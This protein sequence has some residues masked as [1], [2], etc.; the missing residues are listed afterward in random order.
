MCRGG[1]CRWVGS[2]FHL[3]VPADL[4][5]GSCHLEPDGKGGPTSPVVLGR[6]PDFRSFFK[7]SQ[8]LRMIPD[9]NKGIKKKKR[10]KIASQV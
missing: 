3:N 2:C 5:Q 1:Q 8:G 10:T 4:T 9:S 7:A 6:D